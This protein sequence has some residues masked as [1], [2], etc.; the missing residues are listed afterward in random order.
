MDGRAARSPVGRKVLR[1][2]RSAP[3]ATT[4]T[5]AA[6]CASSGEHI[7]GG[8]LSLGGRGRCGGVAA[9]LAA[10]D[11]TD[12]KLR[13]VTHLACPPGAMRA[14]TADGAHRCQGDTYTL[15]VALADPR[16]PQS[17]ASR[18]AR[19]PMWRSPLTRF[20]HLAAQG[21][22]D[23]AMRVAAASEE[24]PRWLLAALN[25]SNGFY[26][27]LGA[28][29]NTRCPPPVL[30]ALARDGDRIL[31]AAVAAN[32]NCPQPL[33]DRMSERLE[34]HPDGYLQAQVVKAK[35]HM[36]EQHLDALAE[37][38]Q[39]RVRAAV[40]ARDDCPDSVLEMLAA[41]DD[42]DVRAAVAGNVR[43]GQKLIRET[44]MKDPR[45][46]VRIA[47]A[48]H[49]ELLE[50]LAA[51]TEPDVRAAAAAHP[52]CP[53][54]C[55]EDLASDRDL[56][57]RAAAA[58]HPRCPP[59]RLAHLVTT[60]EMDV[61]AAA[62]GN[63]S[64][65][66]HLLSLPMRLPEKLANYAAEVRTAIAQRPDTGHLLAALASDLEPAVRFAVATN[67]AASTAVLQQL[68]SDMADAP[69]IAAREHLVRRRRA[70]N[71]NT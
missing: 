65:P 16:L 45:S 19:R 29:E 4:Q 10:S 62:V 42:Q 15:S 37:E 53:V 57:V 70:T 33:L 64:V 51:D 67:P 8:L 52:D 69:R 22:S 54:G 30:P 5:L 58:K 14:L 12:H 21:G 48:R 50:T 39:W 61:V 1:A 28:A 44:L 36:S 38:G 18:N 47:A 25:T 55:L 34:E 9:A 27:L 6:A 63:L 66:I 31:K 3:A 17:V 43:C 46:A 59:G 71:R 13:A 35:R 49:G 23:T 7:R 24:C 32:P 68:A 40:A 20:L 60:R 26:A 56:A 41:D 11:S 2:A